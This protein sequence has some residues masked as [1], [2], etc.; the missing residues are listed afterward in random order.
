MATVYGVVLAGIGAV[1]Y[2]FAKATG[3]RLPELALGGLA[4][5]GALGAALASVPYLVAGFLDQPASSAV[6]DND[7]PGELLNAL[8]VAGH[9]AFGVTALA[10]AGLAVKAWRGGERV[11]DDPWGG[12]TLEWATTSPPPADN[13]ADDPD[14]DVAGAAAR[15]QGQARLRRARVGIELMHALP[16]APVPPPRRQVLIGTA[17][18]SLGVFTL[19]GGLLAVYIRIREDARDAGEPWVPESVS[20]PGVPT[21]VMLIS[22]FALVLF[23]QWAVYAARR[24][25]RAHI[26]L[27]LG[28]VGVVGLAIV[29]AQ[30]YVYNRMA[31]PAADSTYASLFYAVTGTM[32]GPGRRRLGVHGRSPPSACSAAASPI[33]RSSPLTPCTGTSSPPPSPPCG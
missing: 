12:Q 16:P 1:A 15:S 2:W 18:A 3:R 8:V 6:W 23:A 20:I 25:D 31:L 13:F 26:G 7:G 9:A 21:N 33:R 5:L 32:T 22:F 10:F 4:T 17:V 24:R 29:N 14:G 27:S 30:A 11:G 28:L 19:I